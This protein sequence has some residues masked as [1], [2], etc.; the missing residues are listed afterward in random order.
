ME[1]L[2]KTLN[3]TQFKRDDVILCICKDSEDE[4]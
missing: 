4:I 2:K 3:L 1:C